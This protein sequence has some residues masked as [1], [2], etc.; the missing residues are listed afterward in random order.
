MRVV[1]A[2]CGRVGLLLASRLHLDG[3]DVSVID[4]EPRALSRLGASFSG[5]AIRGV[6]FDRDVL[7]RA[8]I[9]RAD[10]F[11]AVTSGDNSNVVASIVAREVFRVPHVI[12]RIYDP[13]RAEI[14][15]RFGIESV[16]SVTWSANEIRALLGRSAHSEALTFGDGEARLVMAHVPPRLAG[17]ALSS[18]ERPGELRVSAIVR[19]GAA[20]VPGGG[21]EFRE[22]DLV[23]V[24]VSAGALGHL[25]RTFVP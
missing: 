7:I 15:R 14:Y 18:V 23:Y 11:I 5:G 2:G 3:H 17:R 4:R 19:S 9:E 13:R 8:G 12:A 1:I 21:E 6:V 22:G 16:S 20:F 25:E 10:A 24:S